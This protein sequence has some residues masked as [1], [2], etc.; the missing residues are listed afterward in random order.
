MRT[1]GTMLFLMCIFC[2]TGCAESLDDADI[3]PT[4]PTYDRR[5]AASLGGKT[6]QGTDYCELAGW[7]GDGYCDTFCPDPDPDCATASSADWC[8][9]YGFYGDDFC[10]DFCPEIDPD[11]LSDDMPYLPAADPAQELIILGCEDLPYDA[12]EVT[13]LRAEG[14]I[15]HVEA[16]YA[17]GCQPHDFELCWDGV[18]DELS[19]PLVAFALSHDSNGETCGEVLRAELRFNLTYFREV[20]EMG[21]GKWPMQI[22]VGD[23]WLFYDPS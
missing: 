12:L 7:Y 15:L 10:D 9:E 16:H 8:E 19:P 13:Q 2:W 22:S 4:S 5:E 14:E 6:D 21:S 17:G 11:C 20:I 23:R 3:T 1:R 18:I